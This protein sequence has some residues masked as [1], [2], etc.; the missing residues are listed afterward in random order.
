MDKDSYAWRLG[1]AFIKDPLRT[2]LYK[3][4]LHYEKNGARVELNGWSLM[5]FF[6]GFAVALVFPQVTFL[7]WFFIHMA[8]ELYQISIGMSDIQGDHVSESI[9]IAFDTIFA[10]VGFYAGKRLI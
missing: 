1:D 6:S 10:M 5:H 7:L 8:W 3:N 4:W 2:K 9:D